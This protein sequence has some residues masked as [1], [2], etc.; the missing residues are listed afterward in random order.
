MKRAGYIVVAGIIV[1]VAIGWMLFFRN[2]APITPSQNST[3]TGSPSSSAPTTTIP[4]G[5]KTYRNTTHRLT[6][7][8][9]PI[10]NVEE[11]ANMGWSYLNAD[12]GTNIV[13]V[14]IDEDFQ[15][16]TNFREAKFHVGKSDDQIVVANCLKREYED[17]QLRTETI[18]GIAFTVLF[19]GGAGAGNFYE[20]ESYRVVRGNSCFA[21]EL[22]VHSTN[23]GNYPEEMNI[24]EFDSKKVNA[25]LRQIIDSFTFF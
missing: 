24:K 23:V 6:F 25:L 17:Q 9:P 14:T 1:G 4:T 15:P 2:D 3:S 5:W 16:G 12:P 7:N 8:Y 20:T 21:V 19:E 10:G 13:E 18:N 11:T 22:L